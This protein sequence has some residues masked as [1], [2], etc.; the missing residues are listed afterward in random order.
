M[1]GPGR[2]IA[3]LYAVPPADFVRARNSVAARLRKAGRSEEAGEV[4]RLRKPSP[5][6]WAVNRLAGEAP[7]EL[8]DLVKAV[9]RLQG[10]QLKAGPGLAEATT[11]QRTALEQLV[12]RARGLLT[13]AGLA[14]TPAVLGKVSA[15]IVGAVVDPQARAD[16]Q[17]GR[18]TE[19]RSAPGF[20]A[21]GLRPVLRE[22]RRDRA[23]PRDGEAV[24]PAPAAGP[25]G[26]DRRARADARRAR[27]AADR[28]ARAAGRRAA[29]LERQAARR[30][31]RAD[32][33][34][35]AVERITAQLRQAEQRLARER[36]ATDEAARF[37]ARAR[38]E[39]AH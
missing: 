23:A 6:L 34:A 14:A 11:R 12:T 38:R 22:P 2:D 19:E 17:R 20:D 10:A 5:A 26:P 39:A 24:R 29:Q 31:R 21:F 25:A 33:A 32:Q 3:D 9:E 18:L 4:Q 8:T 37:A 36:Q 35:R 28:E 30:Q 13:G 1:I 15:T 16:L 27:A 7:G